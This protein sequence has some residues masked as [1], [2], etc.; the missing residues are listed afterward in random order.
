MQSLKL[1]G[2]GDL[3]FDATGGLVLVEGTEE[4]AQ[5][6]Q[7]GIGTNKGEW[8]LNPSMGI[9]FSLFLGKKVNEEEMR[10]E[11]IEG[12]LQDERIQSVDS[13]D[14]LI[15]ARERTMLVSFVATSTKGDLI[16][17]EEVNIGAG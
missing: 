11:L 17:V 6:C 14:F 9:T 16:Q 7:I 1:D 15:H 3:M 2:T 4:V 8:F 10:S 12:I 5:C 13:V